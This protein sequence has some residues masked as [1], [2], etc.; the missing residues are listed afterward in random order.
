MYYNRKNSTYSQY[1]KGL[2]GEQIFENYC[3]RNGIDC[4]KATK[5]EDYNDKVDFITEMGSV[6]VKSNYSSKWN[7][8]VIE[9]E[10]L[11]EGPDA[12]I[13]HNVDNFAFIVEQ[14]VYIVKAEV[15]KN[16]NFSFY[17]T[18]DRMQSKSKGGYRIA[19]MPLDELEDLI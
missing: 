5:D 18:F 14:D 12:W 1:N 7:T 17:R 13:T 2:R 6:A 19:F 4:R 16:H 8:I 11:A 10:Q 3:E 15:L 9:L